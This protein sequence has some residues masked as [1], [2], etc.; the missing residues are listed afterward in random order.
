MFASRPTSALAV[1]SKSTREK[2]RQLLL[3][4]VGEEREME[5]TKKL[6]GRKKRD[7]RHVR[8]GSPSESVC[9][10]KARGTDI[11]CCSD[12]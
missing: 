4:V 9:T 1:P 8:G 3:V 11:I 2:E 7:F 10:H 6:S 12:S 5:G